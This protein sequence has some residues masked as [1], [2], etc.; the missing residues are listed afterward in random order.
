MDDGNA[1]T[2]RT[3]LTPDQ[4]YT[5]L[6]G[7]VRPPRLFAWFEIVGVVQLDSAWFE[8]RGFLDRRV[9]RL[10]LRTSEGI[11]GAILRGKF[12]HP[13]LARIM[14]GMFAVAVLVVGIGSILQ[15]GSSS[16]V[17]LPAILCVGLFFV[18]RFD[19]SVRTKREIELLTF[20][21]ELLETD[22]PRQPVNGTVIR[23]R[24]LQPDH[25]QTH[26][27]G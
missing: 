11:D 12:R 17:F 18:F 14:Y 2:I 5:I 8:N 9:R 27:T 25:S 6:Q 26:P 19:L 1:I 15:S 24:H 4:V 13:P 21:R 10:Y 20:L 23:P 3:H 7:A 22:I 16:S